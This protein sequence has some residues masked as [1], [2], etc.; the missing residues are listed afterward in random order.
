MRTNIFRLFVLAL[1]TSLAHASAGPAEAHEEGVLTVASPS[2]AA[3]SA[4]AVSG[5][6]FSGSTSF[7]L[8]LKGALR[9]Y[10]LGT[11][12]SDT[13]GAFTREIVIPADVRPGAYRLVAV[14][15][16]GDEAAEVD[17]EVEEESG[18]DATGS[19]ARSMTQPRADELSI[20]RSYSGI[21][22]FLL[23]VLFGG[24]LAGGIA[25]YRRPKTAA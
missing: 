6:H 16:D 8:L 4:L 12:D 1:T 18:G 23:G 24:A 3:G 2:A 15:P 10:E 7:R 13:A 17:L 9:E 21:E 25:L 5:E 22:W 14:A 19:G 20:E 11:I